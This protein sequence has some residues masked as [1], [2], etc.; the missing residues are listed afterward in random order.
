MRLVSFIF[1]LFLLIT[2]AQISPITGGKKDIYAPAI[3]ESKSFPKN[4]ELNF[5]GTEIIL[6]FDEFIKLNKA[7]ENIIITP[8]LDKIPSISVKNKTFSLLFNENLKAN[9]TYVVNFN[10]AIQDITERNDSIFQYVLSTGSF[11]DSISISG[12]VKDS[13]TNKPIKNCFI[14]IYPNQDTIQFDSIPYK[15]KPTYI[16]Q[17]NKMGHYKIDYLKKG[18]YSIFAFTDKNKNM[19]FNFDNEKIGFLSQQTIQLDTSLNAVDFRLFNVDAEQTF[20]TKTE[21]TYPGRLEIVLNKEPQSFTMRSNVEIVKENTESKDSLIYW[22][23]QKPTSNIQFYYTLNGQEEDTLIPYLKNQPKSNDSK[24]P[25]LEKLT[26]KTNIINSNNLLPNDNLIIKIEEPILNIDESKFHFLDKDSNAVKVEIIGTENV[27]E[28]LFY[29]HGVAKYL[30]IDSLAIESMFGVFNHNKPKFTFENLISDDY[31]GQLF[32]KFDSLN[33]NFIFE[34]LDDKQ[35]VAK[36]YPAIPDET[37]IHFN[38]LKPGKYQLRIIS[39]KNKDGKWNKGSLQNNQQ[40]ENIFYYT[41]EIKI[42]SKWDL[43]IDVDLK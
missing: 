40:S 20:L 2:C 10:G 19:L 30:Q 14:A 28:I 4:G 18:T 29:T 5:D 26:L 9:T 39:D 36:V 11:I 31:F 15:L 43:E 17:T 6:K 37:L 35:K 33:G 25:V 23:A 13:Y 24:T 8:Q 38:N 7:S 16:G 42:R 3:V 34:L 27:N 41:D 21:F 12:V 32:V 1:L 22:L